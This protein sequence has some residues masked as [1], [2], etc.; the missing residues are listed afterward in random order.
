[1]C[2]S[3]IRYNSHD[4]A[5]TAYWEMCN[6]RDDTEH[7]IYYECPFC[8]YWHLGNERP[9]MKGRVSLVQEVTGESESS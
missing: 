1:M 8:H 5:Q 4:D 6:K 2:G 9:G 7:L 3:K